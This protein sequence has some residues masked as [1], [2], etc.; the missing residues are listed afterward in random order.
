MN[1]VHG[2]AISAS[3]CPQPQPQPKFATQSATASGQWTI[4]EPTRKLLP[5]PREY[6]RQELL[7]AAESG[8]LAFRHIG[9]VEER[10][11]FAGKGTPRPFT[12]ALPGEMMP[13]ERVTEALDQWMV[14]ITDPKCLYVYKRDA[15][16]NRLLEEPSLTPDTL[17]IKLLSDL[18][19][20]H[21]KSRE[22]ANQIIWRVYPRFT[23]GHLQA[24]GTF[25][26]PKLKPGD[27]THIYNFPELVLIHYRKE[28]IKCFCVYNDKRANIADIL[29][30]K[31]QCEKA[32]ELKPLPLVVY[33]HHTGS[34]QVC[35]DDELD[36][37]HLANNGH[38][39]GDFAF[40]QSIDL[41]NFRAMLNLL[42]ITL[43][44]EA[45]SSELS[46]PPDMMHKLQQAIELL[47]D[48][49]CYSCE[50]L[51]ELKQS[52]LPIDQRFVKK[53]SVNIFGVPV[54][55][56][57]DIL[58]DTEVARHNGGMGPATP[59]QQQQEEE[60]AYRLC[61]LLLQSGARPTEWGLG[62]IN[63]MEEFFDSAMPVGIFNCMV[64]TSAPF[65]FLT[66]QHLQHFPLTSCSGSVVEFDRICRN[67]SPQQRQTC[68]R[69]ALL[70][71]TSLMHPTL[72]HIQ[73]H[74]LALF[75]HGASPNKDLLDSVRALLAFH[76]P[77]SKKIMR[78][79]SPAEYIEWFEKLWEQR[80]E[81]PFYQNWLERVRHAKQEIADLKRS[82]GINDSGA[83]TTPLAAGTPTALQFMV[84]AFSKPPV[85]PDHVGDNEKTILTVLQHYYRR[86]GPERVIQNLGRQ[87]MPTVW[88]PLHSCSHVLRARNNGHWYMELLEKFQ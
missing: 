49:E 15:L 17:T 46:V 28:E 18:R 63:N 68:L 43:R 10:N 83:L 6:E 12:L 31:R 37:P 29:E 59:A 62:H 79:Y 81:H 35:F 24:N 72:E 87:T 50:R 9:L 19:S 8:R 22:R 69:K 5:H 42:P 51:L 53:A 20:L 36:S 84:D 65:E 38:S 73:C 80:N 32:L 57:L 55:S 56:L 23:S 64:A 60:E 13:T 3:P 86:P 26:L 21:K 14:G 4:S 41:D 34:V 61:Q 27:Y 85:L 40:S 82:L 77:R 30:S 44:A 47:S 67:I 2:A 78:V 48:P 74:L 52:G 16:T 11:Y 76:Y 1:V 71:V 25:S 45:L 54:K 39:L 58:L 66:L 75:H 88:K 33:C 70:Y 7:R